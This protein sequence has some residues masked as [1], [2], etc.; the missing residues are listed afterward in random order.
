MKQ[1]YSSRKNC[2]PSGGLSG[3]LNSQGQWGKASKGGGSRSSNFLYGYAGSLGVEEQ[4]PVCLCCFLSF[5]NTLRMASF[6]AF[7]LSSTSG[8]AASS[9]AAQEKRYSRTLII[10]FLP[11]RATKNNNNKKKT[12]IPL[13]LLW[14]Y[15]GFWWKS[16]RPMTLKTRVKKPQS[17]LV[18]NKILKLLKTTKHL[19]ALKVL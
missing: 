16:L 1:I 6:Q 18:W 3:A 14:I 7:C 5:H 13:P 15:T 17:V 8:V 9:Q 10:F 2:F 12:S 19:Q 4:P 11:A